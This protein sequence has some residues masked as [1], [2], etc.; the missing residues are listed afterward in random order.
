MM[1]CAAFM[2]CWDDYCSVGSEGIGLDSFKEGERK[3]IKIHELWR[4]PLEPV[5]KGACKL[6]IWDCLTV[7]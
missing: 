7:T 5:M 4:K 3:E 6:I 2:K 1:V